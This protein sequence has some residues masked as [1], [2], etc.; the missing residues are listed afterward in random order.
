MV[1]VNL[2][3]V[4]AADSGISVSL[5]QFHKYI[6]NQENS[7]DIN[8]LIGDSKYSSMYNVPRKSY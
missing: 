1:P 5:D 6:S 8:V 4:T 7:G 3:R 2:Q